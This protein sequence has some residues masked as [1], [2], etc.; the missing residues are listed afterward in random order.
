MVL[1]H[2]IDK[3][4]SA[5]TEREFTTSADLLCYCLR[6]DCKYQVDYIITIIIYFT[7]VLEKC[8]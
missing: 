4:R 5:V 1:Y 8:L 3:L 7:Q 6:T 2:C